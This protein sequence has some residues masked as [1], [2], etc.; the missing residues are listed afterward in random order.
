MVRNKKE[1]HPRFKECMKFIADQIYTNSDLTA[2][3][4][5]CRV[6]QKNS[7]SMKFK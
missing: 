7:I 3:F 1:W 5:R 2:S 4:K 6:I